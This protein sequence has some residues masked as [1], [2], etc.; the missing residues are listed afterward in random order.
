[1]EQQ[2]EAA[3]QQSTPENTENATG[4]SGQPAEQ[5]RGVLTRRPK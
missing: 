1:M 4:Q 3:Q 5:N 2:Q